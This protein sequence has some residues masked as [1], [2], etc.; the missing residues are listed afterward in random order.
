[1]YIN[2]FIFESVLS[3]KK[4]PCHFPLPGWISVSGI[5]WN[6]KRPLIKGSVF[7]RKHRAFNEIPA[8]GFCHLSKIMPWIVNWVN[9]SSIHAVVD[10]IF[11]ITFSVQWENQQNEIVIF[12]WNYLFTQVR[13]TLSPRYARL[14]HL[15]HL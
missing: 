15:F 13:H 7:I 3:N 2:Y 11:N 8:T 4:E 9:R 12:F 1:M 6:K 5:I 14:S 10:A